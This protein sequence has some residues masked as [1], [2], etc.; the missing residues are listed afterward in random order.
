MN[1]VNKFGFMMVAGM[2]SGA[3]LAAGTHNGGH[4]HHQMNHNGGHHSSMMTMNSPVGGP[5]KESEVN[6][7]IEVITLDTMRYQF[8]TEPDIKAGDVVKFVVTNQGKITHELSI[9]DEKEQ[10]AHR[11]MMKK[12]PD[13]QHEDGSTI[14]V[15]PGETETLIWKFAGDG[16]ALFACNIPGHYEAGMSYKAQIK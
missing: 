10:H 14:S 12:M 2:F 4:E 13:M 3:V 7:V 5:G 9:G 15:K 6:K 8:K 16:E 1:V 11:E